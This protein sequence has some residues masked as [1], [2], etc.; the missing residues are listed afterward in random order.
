MN[1]KF[2]FDS[3]PDIGGICME[4][5]RKGEQAPIITRALVHSGQHEFH[6]Y[7]LKN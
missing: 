2:S 7:I 4:S 1:T 3:V 5:G 6:I